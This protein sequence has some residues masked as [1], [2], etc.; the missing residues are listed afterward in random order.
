MG[1]VEVALHAR[2]TPWECRDR[3]PYCSISSCDET[4][5]SSEH[6]WGSSR[7]RARRRFLV[8][9]GALCYRRFGCPKVATL[10]PL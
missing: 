6:A 8:D 2:V 4:G 5:D 3:R 10:R 1:E 7:D 9:E